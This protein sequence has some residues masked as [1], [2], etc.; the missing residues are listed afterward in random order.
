MCVALTF[1][2]RVRLII[3]HVKP[4]RGSRG[5]LCPAP[6]SAAPGAGRELHRVLAD[7][8]YPWRCDED[9]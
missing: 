6:L 9:L 1:N 5:G 3:P 7:T 4:G 8:T 2:Y